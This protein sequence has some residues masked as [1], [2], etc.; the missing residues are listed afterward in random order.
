MKKIALLSLVGLLILVFGIIPARASSLPR[1]IPGDTEI[2]IW[3]PI[4]RTYTLTKDI[5]GSIEIVE[6]NLI[7]DGANHKINGLG[8]GIYLFQRSNVMV[9]NCNI[10]DFFIAIFCSFSSSNILANNT[11][12]NSV[13]GIYLNSSSSNTLTD[14]IL[15]NN[16]YGVLL[17]F[18]YFNALITNT[19]INNQFGV[20]FFNCGENKTYNNNF[21]DN[22]IQAYCI[23]ASSDNEFFLDKIFGGNYWS[24]WIKPDEDNN[25]FVDYP[26]VFSSGHDALP[27]ICQ[28]G[29]K[30]ITLVANA[31]SDKKVLVGEMLQIDGSG[32][33]APDGVI[34]SYDWDF[35]DGNTGFGILVSYRYDIAGIYTVILTVTD[36]DLTDTDTAEITVQTPAEAIGDLITTIEDFGLPK[37]IEKSLIALLKAAIKSLE[38]YQEQAVIGQLTGFIHHVEAQ[39]DKKLTEEQAQMLIGVAQRI[40]DS[41]Q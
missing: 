31:G 1:Y 41:I 25:G 17:Y 26:Y 40:I 39:N 32:S 28:D 24:N 20:Y 5:N 12:K 4:K 35:G 33:Y 7:L 38:K 16:W 6:N 13:Y 18:S 21:I 27:W 19:A 9:K 22:L 30:Y 14:N 15:I 36:D 2:G 8:Y 11:I 37:G 34:E 23:D 10:S 29:W 3:D